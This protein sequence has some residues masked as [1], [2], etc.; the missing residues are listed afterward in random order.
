MLGTAGV[1]SWAMVTVADLRSDRAK[2]SVE[3]AVPTDELAL[4][5]RNEQPEDFVATFGAVPEASFAGWQN[6]LDL[7]SKQPIVPPAFVDQSKAGWQDRAPDLPLAAPPI[8]PS[9]LESRQATSA[10][11]PVPQVIGPQG[12]VP[13]VAAPQ[14]PAGHQMHL[15]RDPK[16]EVVRI[17]AQKSHRLAARPSY[18]EK[19]VEQGDAGDV[20][21]RY[22]RHA[23]APPHM[24]DIC[25]MPPKN[26]RSIV[27]QRL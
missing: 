25:Y 2:R 6:D 5:P 10:Q 1:V 15:V 3:S 21:F 14:A 18:V 27:V 12:P 19:I 9:D 13:Q 23:C 16:P 4:P 22:R 26:R 8:S 20:K 17:A 7:L 24:V 11:L